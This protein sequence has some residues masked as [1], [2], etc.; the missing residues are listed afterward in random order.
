MG[1]GDVTF[2]LAMNYVD[3]FLASTSIGK[4]QLQLLGAVCLLIAS[5]L[6]QCKAI[7]PEALIFYSD[8]SLSLADI[9]VSRD[10]PL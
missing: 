4:E 5:K 3:R 1:C 10:S 6:R 8:Y 9:T 2:P 7:H